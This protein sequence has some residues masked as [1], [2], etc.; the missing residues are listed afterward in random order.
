MS[1]MASIKK[2]SKR[3]LII[4]MAVA[5]VAAFTPAVAWSGMGPVFGGMLLSGKK[6]AASM[7]EK[8]NKTR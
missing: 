7:L 6:A 3:I 8:I 5:T 4:A 2:I 1:Y